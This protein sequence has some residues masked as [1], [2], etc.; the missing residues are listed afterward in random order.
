MVG[1]VP[2]LEVE[3]VPTLTQP[4]S[5]VVW[6]VTV[7]PVVELKAAAVQVPTLTQPGSLV[8]HWMVMPTGSERWMKKAV[9]SHH[10]PSLPCC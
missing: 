4:V 10:M 7:C 8:W 1:P 6:Q 3:Q 5:L 2:G 9:S